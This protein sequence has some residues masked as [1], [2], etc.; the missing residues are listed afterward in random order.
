MFFNV[1]SVFCLQPFCITYHCND[2]LTKKQQYQCRYY[3][4]FLRNAD[5]HIVIL[6]E[7]LLPIV[8]ILLL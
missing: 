4:L 6:P 1:L 2:L 7:K 8:G 5:P 3:I